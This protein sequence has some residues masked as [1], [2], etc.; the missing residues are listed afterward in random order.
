MQESDFSSNMQEQD[1]ALTAQSASGSSEQYEAGL[2]QADAFPARAAP[3][4]SGY[5]PESYQKAVSQG[6]GLQ[7]G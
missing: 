2:S 1:E 6:P 3:E 5:L 7:P 4:R